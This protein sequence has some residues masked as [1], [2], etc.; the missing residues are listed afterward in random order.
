[1][2]AEYP[3]NIRLRAIDSSIPFGTNEAK[4]LM[5]RLLKIG[6]TESANGSRIRCS[7]VKMNMNLLT[8]LKKPAVGGPMAA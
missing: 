2:T 4:I 3:G 5:H 1:M 6:T 8:H 7:E